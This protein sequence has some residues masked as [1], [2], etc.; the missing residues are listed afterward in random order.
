MSLAKQ[1]SISERS[2]PV[3]TGLSEPLPSGRGRRLPHALIA[4]SLANL[5]FLPAAALLLDNKDHHYYNQTSCLGSAL[6]ALAANIVGLSLLLFGLS[7]VSRHW[8][9]GFLSLSRDLAFCCLLLVPLNSLRFFFNLDLGQFLRLPAV[10]KVPG[11]V[12]ALLALLGMVRWHRRVARGA[13]AFV[14]I[15]SPLAFLICGCLV[16][17]LATPAPW[18]PAPQPPMVPAKDWTSAPRLL[19]IIF[20]EWDQRLA[21]LE[22]PSGIALPELDRLTAESLLATNAFSPSTLTRN[23]M[24][25]L[26]TGR[27]VTN[28]TPVSDHELLLAYADSPAPVPWSSQPT[29]FQRARELGLNVA[30]VGWYHPYARLFSGAANYIA[31]YPTG[32]GI[33]SCDFSENIANQILA[34]LPTFARREHLSHFQAAFDQVSSLVT[35]SAFG[36]IFWHA[37]I[38]HDPGIYDPA[39]KRVSTRQYLKTTGY[40]GNLILCD[41]VLGKLRRD[42]E[43]AHLW[44]HTWVLLSADHSLRDERFGKI[45]RRVPFILKAPGTNA[46]I[47]YSQTLHTVVTKDLLLAILR[48]DVR[49]LP[50]VSRWLDA[51]VA[52]GGG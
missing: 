17:R 13:A 32:G 8:S 2:L 3:T 36:F 6:A 43:R 29:V 47:V 50:E 15:L 12:L 28:S 9:R 21:L 52:P 31:S 33:D 4:F 44:D 7:R 24:P 37:P 48:A 18:T 27:I 49:S 51:H 46:P 42:L 40:L 41:E 26:T 23:A 5:F 38:P 30:V 25:A 14:L 22:R 20:D 10:L 16:Y 35:N 39:R 1:P 11:L 19:W 45:D 34:G